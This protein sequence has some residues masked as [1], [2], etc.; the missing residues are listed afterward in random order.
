MSCYN[1]GSRYAHSL[2]RPRLDN[3]SGKSKLFQIVKLF[4]DIESESREVRDDKE[5]LFFHFTMLQ[6]KI[7]KTKTMGGN[8][9][10]LFTI[11]R[12]GKEQKKGFVS[13][14]LCNVSLYFCYSIVSGPGK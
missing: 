11:M 3:N 14:F 4:F 9:I 8:S 13:H 5:K 1:V 2:L 6:M 10:D 7:Q 12:I